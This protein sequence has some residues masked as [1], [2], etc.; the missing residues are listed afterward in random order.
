MPSFQPNPR[1]PKLLEHSCVPSALRGGHLGLNLSV[2]R[3]PVK[4]A[5]GH[6]LAGA[7]G[8]HIRLVARQGL[9]MV[10]SCAVV[11][12]FHVATLEVLPMLDCPSHHGDGVQRPEG[13]VSGLLQPSPPPIIH[14]LHQGS[15][16]S[17]SIKREE[18]KQQQGMNLNSG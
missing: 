3:K 16:S 6:Q 5:K 4:Q 9:G 15:V 1:I 17:D 11:L 10:G 12:G 14:N 13:K 2:T 8:V 18:E 7:S